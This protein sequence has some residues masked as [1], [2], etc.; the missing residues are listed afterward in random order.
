MEAGG[1]DVLFRAELSTAALLSAL[2]SFESSL[3]VNLSKKKLLH[4]RLR[5]TQVNGINL[6]LGG[7]LDTCSLGRTSVAHFPLGPVIT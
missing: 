2:T 7:I 6:T 3:S 1:I 4:R 5:A